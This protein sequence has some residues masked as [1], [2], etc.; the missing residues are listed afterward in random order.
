MTVRMSTAQP[1]A[2]PWQLGP[3]AMT[4]WEKFPPRPAATT[5]AAT[6]RT[7]PAVV[8]RL[9]TPPFLVQDSKTR[10]NRKV[11]LLRVLD[12]LERHPGETWQDRW[13]ATGAGLDGRADWRSVLLADLRDVGDVGARTER[14]SSILGMGLVQLICDDILR[15]SLAWLLATASPVRIANEMARVRDPDGFDRLGAV[16]ASSTVGDA[17]FLPAVERIALILAAKGGTVTASRAQQHC[18]LRPRA[19]GWAGRAGTRQTQAS[20]V[21]GLVAPHPAGRFTAPPRPDRPPDRTWPDFGVTRMP[22]KGVGD[23][24]RKNTNPRRGHWRVC[25]PVPP[26]AVERH[27]GPRLRSDPRP[28]EEDRL[29][30]AQASTRPDR[31]DRFGGPLP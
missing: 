29:A 30:V 18:A 22:P 28:P 7:R 6:E 14:I 10:C 27:L 13:E 5:W 19:P 11:A 20:G 15:P 17:T 31:P 8:T 23:C 16:R 25:L 2:R 3:E 1:A 12:W 4:L 9:L 21:P 24:M 26:A